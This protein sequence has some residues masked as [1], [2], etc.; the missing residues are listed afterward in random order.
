MKKKA[1]LVF[2]FL[3][4]LF[5][6]SAQDE[7]DYFVTQTLDTIY[8]TNLTY[9]T[10]TWGG[11][12]YLSYTR[13]DGAPVVYKSKKS[14]PLVLTLYIEG[15]TIDRI[16]LK[17]N[18]KKEIRYTKRTVDG[19]LR[20]YLVH[21]NPSNSGDGTVMY[22]FYIK[23]ADGKFYKINKKKNMENVIIPYLKE[24][25]SFTRSYKGEFSNKEEEFI[26]MIELYNELCDQ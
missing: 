13:L 21:Q 14:A 23:L 19:K 15:S 1:S 8:C 3:L 26:E 18:S 6:L 22:M 2:L 4:P 12:N 10:A 5:S 11:L 20:V 17:P 16:P 9:R 24:C 7:A 25:T